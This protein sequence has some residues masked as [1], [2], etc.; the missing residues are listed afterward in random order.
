[1]LDQLYLPPALGLAGLIVA[2]IIYGIIKKSYA[3][4]D[5]IK[6]IYVHKISDEKINQI[7]EARI[8][9]T[10]YERIKNPVDRQIALRWMLTQRNFHPS[11]ESHWEYVKHS[12][13]E[14]TPIP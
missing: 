1:M 10:L 12:I 13:L 2:F 3:P 9:E 7:L 4:Q 8:V 11:I 5:K 6:E 14:K